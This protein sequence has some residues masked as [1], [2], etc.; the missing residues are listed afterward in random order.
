MLK[1]A[2]LLL[3]LLFAAAPA[4][5]VSALVLPVDG[6]GLLPTLRS[7]LEGGLRHALLAERD[8]AR[9]PV[10][11]LASPEDTAAVLADAA[12]AGLACSLE[13][14]G[15]LVRIGVIAGVDEVFA[16]IALLEGTVLQLRVTRVEVTRRRA[17]VVAAG[18]VVHPAQD[19]GRT[20]VR[21]TERLLRR[22]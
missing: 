7:A 21:L 1:P 22:E 6:P 14:A 5:A 8:G 17:V 3:S 19:D 18:V 10:F 9:R 12:G 13:D 4:G 15:C 16:P 2:V 20:L 11:E